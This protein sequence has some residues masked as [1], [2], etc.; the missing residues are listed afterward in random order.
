[1]SDYFLADDLSGALDAAA[2]F[3]HAGRRVRVVLRPESWHATAA[4][5]VVGVTTETRNAAPALAAAAVGRAMDH[6]AKQGARLVYKKIDSTLR[7][8]IAAELAALMQRWPEARV[9]FS[10]ANP[11][12]GRTVGAGVLRVHGVPVSETEFARDPVSPVTESSLHR[13][14]D[15]LPADR[16][17][18]ADAQT[19]ADL[20][21]AV[22]R[23][24]A[25]KG[26]WVAVGSGALARP[27]AAHRGGVSRSSTAAAVITSGPALLVCGSAHAANRRQ[28]ETLTRARGVS[29]R[30]VRPAAASILGPEVAAVLEAGTGVALI[31]EETRGDSAIIRHTLAATVK[32]VLDRTTVH[33]LLLTGGETAFA[34]CRA[35]QID[36]LAFA[37]EIEPGLSLAH[38]GTGARALRLAIKPGGF[39]SEKTW[40]H[41][42]DR[43]QGDRESGR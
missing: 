14:L 12:V 8:P 19:E 27:V 38:V 31:V 21:R 2:A 43:L 25:T 17:V 24:S 41:A 26:P 13:L 37:D 42:W 20:N 34:V 3:H 16:L 18:I 40:V 29:V 4:D 5:D 28:A 32:D 6:A 15:G 7:G 1:M 10:P 30:E 39:G 35:L 36:A 9:L 23:M 22:E 33:R 11:A